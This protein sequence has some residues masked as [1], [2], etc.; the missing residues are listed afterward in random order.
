M[1]ELFTEI[2]SNRDEKLITR[3]SAEEHALIRQKAK[4]R[5]VK[6]TTMVRNILKK[7]FFPEEVSNVEGK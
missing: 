6:V 1:R 4:E 3:V 5:G 2:I 7:E